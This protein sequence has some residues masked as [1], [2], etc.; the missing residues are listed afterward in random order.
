MRFENFQNGFVDFFF[1]LQL[2]D[3]LKNLFKLNPSEELDKTLKV[4]DFQ[5]RQMDLLFTRD[6]EM[7]KKIVAYRAIF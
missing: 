5:K 3:N 1:L 2:P 6:V 4:F 7:V